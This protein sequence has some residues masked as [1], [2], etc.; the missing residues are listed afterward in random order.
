MSS[1]FNELHDSEGDDRQMP[2]ASAVWLAA[3]E[4]NGDREALDQL[5][6]HELALLRDRIRASTISGDPATSTSDVAQEAVTRLLQVDPPARFESTSALRAYLWRCAWNLLIDALRR[7]SHRSK[8]GV[9]VIPTES[10]QVE[11][12][13]GI[14]VVERRDLS[15]AVRA[16]MELLDDED[17]TVLDMVYL[18]GVDVA[19]VAKKLGLSSGATVMRL[20]RA[21]RKLAERIRRLAEVIDC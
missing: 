9:E 13:G 17:R 6:R 3:W 16:A 2:D 20:V 11:T 18:R 14:G 19:A 10:E 21:R 7:S 12:T 15:I 1:A 8:M 4:A 5:V